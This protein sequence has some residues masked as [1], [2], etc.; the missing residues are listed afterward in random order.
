MDVLICAVSSSSMIKE[1]ITVLRDLRAHGIKAD[2]LMDPHPVLED[3]QDF[4]K[5]MGIHLVILKDTTTC[6]VRLM[7]KDRVSERKLATSELADW[8]SQK[9]S[10]KNESLEN[11]S[12]AVDTASQPVHVLPGNRVKV[13][14]ITAEKLQG[15]DRKRYTMHV[16]LQSID[17]NI[18]GIRE[19]N[20]ENLH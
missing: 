18:T 8:I 12:T 7:E 10:A 14:F 15:R 6:T 20:E 13:T 9:T 17:E 5:R 4:C 11:M 2:I 1:Q 3:T 19:F 16:S